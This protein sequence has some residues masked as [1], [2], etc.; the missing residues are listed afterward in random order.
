MVRSRAPAPTTTTS[1]LPATFDFLRS[2]TAALAGLLRPPLLL[3]LAAAGA[4]AAFPRRSRLPILRTPG[5]PAWAAAFLLLQFPDIH[6]L[7]GGNAYAASFDLPDV[8][9]RLGAAAERA[10]PVSPQFKLGLA[11]I[12]ALAVGSVVFHLVWG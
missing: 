9:V 10:D 6:V 11:L 5:L 12:S 8:N 4:L 1:H 3:A 7:L 2:R